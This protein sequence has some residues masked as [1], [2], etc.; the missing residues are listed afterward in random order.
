MS[1]NST[2]SSSSSS[3][4]DSTNFTNNISSTSSNTTTSLPSTLLKPPKF[5]QENERLRFATWLYHLEATLAPHKLLIYVQQ[6]VLLDGESAAA[7]TT[8]YGSDLTGEALIKMR[9]D[10]VRAHSILISTL[11][12]TQINLVRYI[13]LGHAYEALEKLKQTYG[14]NKTSTQSYILIDRLHNNK[15]KN[16]ETMTEYISR[17]QRLFLDVESIDPSYNSSLRWYKFI[18]IK[19]LTHLPEYQLLS[20][21]IG[22]LDAKNEWT[23]QDFDQYLITMDEKNKFIKSQSSSHHVEVNDNDSKNSDSNITAFFSRGG[24]IE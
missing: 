4:T 19:G 23:K 14:F 13:R 18:I 20:S 24:Y 6:P 1:L 16:N 9:E 5:P 10:A 7:N 17:T 12:E 15:K 11:N 8:Y 22:T 3:S 2:M 21:L